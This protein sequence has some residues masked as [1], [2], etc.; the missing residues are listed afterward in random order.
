M[1][2]ER[3]GQIGILKGLGYSRRDI[4]VTFL[5]YSG[6]AAALGCVVGYVL[7]VILFPSVIW[8]AYEM[9]YIAIPM[10]FMTNWKLAI[11]VFLV[12]MISTL[13]TTYM[14][15]RSELMEPTASLMRPKA[16]K[17]GKRVFLENIPA[18]WNR[19]RTG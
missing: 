18:V 5:A 8:Y 4:M 13:G 11:S 10:R 12:S 7:G 1:V 17:A 14:S 3:R 15:C 16:P 6:I 2:D 19:M 9:M